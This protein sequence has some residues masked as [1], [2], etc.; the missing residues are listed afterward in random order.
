MKGY[1]VEVAGNVSEEMLREYI[2][3]QEEN[4]KL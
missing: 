1:Y 2:Q 4:D 3:E